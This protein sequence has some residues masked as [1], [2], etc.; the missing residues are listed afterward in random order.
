MKMS[1]NRQ[2]LIRNMMI[3]IVTSIMFV[4]SAF[5]AASDALLNNSKELLAAFSKQVGI[6]LSDIIE[7]E[8]DK[9]EIVAQSPIITDDKK[10]VEEKLAYLAGI[11]DTQ[12]YKKAALID[13]NG[14]CRTILG[15]TVDVSDKVYFEISKN[16]ES[17][18]SAP[19][20][21]KADGGLQISITTPL[22]DE[23]G[24]IIGILFFSKDAEA[25]SEIVTDITFGATGSA[26]VVDETGKNVIN[27]DIQKVIDGVNRIE[28]A[29]TDSKYQELAEITEKQ[30]AGECGTGSYKLDG[31]T[32]F[33]GYAPIEST[34]WSVGISVEM[35][36]M[37]SGL[38]KLTI[39]L[40]VI[41]VVVI[42]LMI[43]A[44]Y[45]NTKKFVNRLVNLKDAVEELSTGNFKRREYKAV[46]DDEIDDIYAALE[47]TK[48]SVSE[49]I[50]TIKVLSD[51]VH[52]KNSELLDISDQFVKGTESINNAVEESTRALEKQSEQLLEINNV[53]D[54]FNGIITE[55]NK[56]II[57]V[58]EKS[59]EM[60]EK[61]N[62]SCEDMDM[63]SAFME[64]LN[65]SF[66][67]FAGEID[68][69]KVNM[70]KINE[71][72]NLI[73]SISEQT[74][75]LALNAAIEAAR[76]GE[77][78]KGFS[79]VA[80]EIRHLAEQSKESTKN[81]YNVIATLLS[82]TESIAKTSENI[83]IEI[84]E[85]EKNVKNTIDSHQ[86][87][88]NTLEEISPMIDRINDSFSGILEEKDK[89]ISRVEEA[90]SVSEEISATSQEISASCNEF[91]IS[92]RTVKDTAN[93]LADSTDEMVSAVEKF[94]V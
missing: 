6:E 63:L 92:A 36:D 58:N 94:E 40:V 37:L 89:I 81:I 21:S 84:S 70:D 77:A 46:K 13:L 38:N 30:I 93:D 25:F 14:T 15:E 3:V 44:T 57:D 17:Y 49:M 5:F 51:N 87:I 88:M 47:D 72:T 61:A 35:R 75:L 26:F 74:N 65:D 27:T 68:E 53:L 18:M 90:T 62:E 86:G 39:G 7:L 34:G 10:T 16:G 56:S 85:G 54:E 79:V 67:S 60:A 24:E 52:G 91:V 41:S 22:R 12:G 20:V 73:S 4:V 69:M 42:L 83:K 31:V 23:K 48:E 78:G 11:V 80:D 2:M 50:T 64:N 29:K 19:N 43:L 76:A 8:I 71:I 59:N 45:G 66:N 1:I 55:N 28:D 9:V 32:K 33:M 82:K